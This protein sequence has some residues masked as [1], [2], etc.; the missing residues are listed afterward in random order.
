MIAVAIIGILAA[1][2]IPNYTRMQYRAKRAEL[3]T[4]IDGIATAELAYDAMFDT[5]VQCG[6]N[7]SIVPGRKPVPWG[8]DVAGFDTIGW[9]PDGDVRGQYTVNL[10]D[11]D[12]SFEVIG[13]SDID[14]DGHYA[15]L[16][17]T[18]ELNPSMESPDDVF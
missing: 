7:P 4:N 3:A 11:G 16:R 2:A 6:A 15:E 5:Y 17:A 13:Q 12:L 8:D 14:G 18:P 1:I 10:T 9:R